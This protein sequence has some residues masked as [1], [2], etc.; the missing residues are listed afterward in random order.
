MHF[1]TKLLTHRA[2]LVILFAF[3]LQVSVVFADTT[4]EIKQVEQRIEDAVVKADIKLLKSV[5][6]DDFRFTHGDGEVQNKAQWLELVAK[7]QVKSR[8][9]STSEVELH[10]NVAI[11][12]GRLDVVWRGEGKDDKYALKYVRVYERR[13][14]KWVLLSHRTIEMLKT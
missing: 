3:V 4:A 5:Y 14:G 9:I 1:G 2:I 12:V 7:R 8:T 13:K 10:E 6:A 11:T